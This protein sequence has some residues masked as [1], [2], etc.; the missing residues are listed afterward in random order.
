MLSCFQK[1]ESESCSCV[2]LR[3]RRAT[4]HEEHYVEHLTSD[5]ETSPLHAAAHELTALLALSQPDSTRE[6]MLGWEAR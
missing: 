6:D 5:S 2:S 4:G 3:G 1:G